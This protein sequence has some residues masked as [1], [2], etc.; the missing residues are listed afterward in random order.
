MKTITLRLS[1]AAYGELEK[2]AGVALMASGGVVTGLADRLLSQLVVR[3]KNDDT[4][5][6]ITTKEERA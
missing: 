2:Q 5:W 3:L 6:T 4:E 1:D